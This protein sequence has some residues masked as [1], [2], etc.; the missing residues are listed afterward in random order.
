MQT[1]TV[2]KFKRADGGTSVSPCKPE[3]EYTERVR[4]IADEGKAVTKDGVNLFFVIDDDSADGYFEIDAP[5]VDESAMQNTE[6]IETEE[7]SSLEE[8]VI[9][10]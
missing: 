2:Y 8:I 7:E 3:T 6:S 5:E 9:V 4:I 10:E 1:K